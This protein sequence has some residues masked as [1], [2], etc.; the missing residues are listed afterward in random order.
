MDGSPNTSS[1]EIFPKNDTQ[2]RLALN[3]DLTSAIIAAVMVFTIFGNALVLFAFYVQPH[4]RKVKY[5]PIISLALADVLCAVTAMPLYITKKSAASEDIDSRLVCDLYRFSYFFTEYASIM[6]LMAISIERFLN[7]KYPLKYRN[8]VRARVMICVLVACWVEA[9]IVS[10]MPFYWRNEKDMECRNSP[11]STWSLMVIS[12]NVLTP[13]V[14]MF[15]SHCYIYW[16]T[17]SEFGHNEKYSSTPNHLRRKT[18]IRAEKWKIERKATISF[19]VVIG[20]FIICWGPSTFYY[21]FQS[22]HPQWFDGSFQ[23]HKDIF[24]AMVKILTFCNSFMNPVIYFWLNMEF[25]NA[26]VRVLKREWQ[27]RSRAGTAN[28]LTMMSLGSVG[29]FH[30]V[31]HV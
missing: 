7:I 23:R 19:S 5:F 28:S 30:N 21:F 15:T 27:A 1:D 31:D 18:V 25:R 11:T 16:K 26:F 24:G 13:F 8:S 10:T 20:V 12:V 17:L 4:L 22:I 14:F 6:S 3:T 9:L 2:D 29:N